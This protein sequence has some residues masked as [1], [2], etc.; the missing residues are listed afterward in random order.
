MRLMTGR[1]DVYSRLGVNLLWQN[2]DRIDALRRAAINDAAV[3]ALRDLGLEL[4][5]K[6]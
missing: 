5:I 1:G 6:L 2:A 3:V 4:L